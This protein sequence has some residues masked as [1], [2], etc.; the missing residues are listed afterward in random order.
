MKM[1]VFNK[2]HQDKRGDIYVFN[3]GEREFLIFFTKKGALRGG[4]FHD[5]REY[6][7]VLEGKIERRL[8]YD[9][10]EEIEIFYEG[11]LG[12]VPPKIPHLVKALS[13]CW[14]LEWHEYPK[15]RVNYE[16]Y[17]KLVEALLHEKN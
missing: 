14:V 6:G 16:P 10:R 7:V 12:V 15:N 5:L 13:D 2:V 9:E 11:D 17:R 3:L 8:M 4:H 1:L